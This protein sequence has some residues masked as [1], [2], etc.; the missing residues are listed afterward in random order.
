MHH[1]V[2]VHQYEQPLIYVKTPPSRKKWCRVGQ[3]A[4]WCHRNKSEKA[5][6][7]HSGSFNIRNKRRVPSTLSRGRLEPRKFVLHTV[8][9]CRSSVHLLTETGP[10]RHLSSELKHAHSEAFQTCHTHPLRSQCGLNSPWMRTVLHVISA[11]RKPNEPRH[12]P[13]TRKQNGRQTPVWFSEKAEEK[14]RSS[15]W[16]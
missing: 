7:A 11:R 8:I 1:T 6:D 3:P 14:R 13:L 12:L 9:M 2:A 16:K 15:F 10:C 5:Q 4:K